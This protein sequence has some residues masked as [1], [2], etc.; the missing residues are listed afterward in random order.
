MPQTIMQADQQETKVDILKTKVIKAADLQGMMVMH[1]KVHK[2]ADLQEMKTIPLNNQ[3]ELRADQV[4]LHHH[5]VAVVAQLEAAVV[6]AVQ[7]H[8][9]QEEV[10]FKI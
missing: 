1:L 7:D 8:Q 6:V 10:N 9:E 2:A 3:P 4:I 5:Q